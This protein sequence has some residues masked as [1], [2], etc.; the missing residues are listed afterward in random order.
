MQFNN[1]VILTATI[2]PP[3]EAVRMAR[4]DPKVRYEDYKKA[5]KFYLAS[6]NKGVIDGLIFADNSFSD[7]SELKEM[8]ELEGLMNK[9]EIMSFKGLNYPPSYGRGFGE[10]KLI[11]YVM[12]NSDLVN[13]SH[14]DTNFWKVTGRYVLRN[15]SKI[16]ESKPNRTDLYCHC[17]D[18]P[19]RWMDLYVMCWNKN[20]Y[21]AVID[22]IY[23]KLREDDKAGSSEVFFRDVVEGYKGTLSIKKR[24][25]LPPKLEG[26][27]GFDNKAYH[28]MGM[29][30]KLREIVNV[31]FPWL[32]I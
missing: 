26:I 3:S 14:K 23:E 19:T 25:K 28:E 6:L 21:K 24:F 12:N 32:W 20:A 2:T 18:Y 10:F 30:Q 1:I 15:L 4:L 31:I 16:I 29:K 13:S 27:R 5:F 22:N 8:V 17:R 7:L 9:V 11:N